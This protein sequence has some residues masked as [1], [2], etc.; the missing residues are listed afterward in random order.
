MA[1]V[2]SYLSKGATFENLDLVDRQG[3]E[4]VPKEMV[5]SQAQAD[6][7]TAAEEACVKAVG[8]K[9]FKKML[10]FKVKFLSRIFIMSEKDQIA[11]AAFRKY[12]LSQQ[13]KDDINMA[14]RYSKAFSR[15]AEIDNNIGAHATKIQSL[16]KK[17]NGADNGMLERYGLEKLK[18]QIESQAEGE[19]RPK[20]IGVPH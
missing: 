1:R 11:A 9:A 20:W 7:Q 17:L 14:V 3:A 8:K 2:L 13:R 18:Q 16:P 19:R 6:A 10:T 4:R 15:K 5:L 12:K